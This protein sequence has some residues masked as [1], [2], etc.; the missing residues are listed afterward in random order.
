MLKIVFMGTPAFSVPILKRLIDTHTVLAV[1]TQP[2][3]PVGRKRL[4]TPSPVKEEAQKHGIPVLQPEKIRKQYEDILAFAPELIVTAAY[5]QIVPKA[6][7]DAPPY[8]CINVHASLLPKYR[9][10]APIHQAIIDGEKQTGIS[11]MYMTEKLDAGAVLSQQAVAITDEDDV[12]TMHDKLSAIGADLLEKTIVALE[13]GTIEAVAQDED[14]AT[15]APNIKREQEVLDWHKPAR[16]LFNQVR[17]MR[18]WPVAYTLINGNRL[19]VWEANEIAGEHDREPGEILAATKQGIDVACG[20]GTIL[21]LT[22]VQPAGK[23]AVL[24]NQLLQGAHPFQVGKRLGEGH[25]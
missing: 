21:R 8:G 3:R 23:K 5:G 4:L 13:Q 20:N 14:K 6:V 2:D 17:G 15:F 24:A 19:K 9:G 16:A 12:Q 25:E 10:G 22:V 18:P 1:V 11:I 7:L